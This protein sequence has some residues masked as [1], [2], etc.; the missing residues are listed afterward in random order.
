MEAPENAQPLKGV[1][2]IDLS[3]I[4]NGPYATFLLAMGGARV[5]K[6]EPPGGEHLRKRST[7]GGAALPFAMLNANKEPISLNLKT[8]KGRDLLLRLIERADVLVENFAPGV[9]E[10]LG[11]DWPVLHAA[12]PRLIYASSSGFGSSGPNRNFPAMDLTVQA[13][14]GVMSVTGFADRPP[15]KSGPA[16]C[17]FFAGIHLYLS[18][19]HI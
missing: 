14:S 17:D 9:M 19:I 18:L 11:V 5:I 6:V 1:T 15:V 12:N 4:Y 16:L 3:Q 7:V 2:V 10:R 8:A 13:M